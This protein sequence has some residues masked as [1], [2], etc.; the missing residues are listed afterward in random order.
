MSHRYLTAP[1]QVRAVD[2]GPAT[3]IVNYRSGQVDTLIGPAARWW[4]ELA[5]SGDTDT[6]AALDHVT[7][8]TLRGQLLEAG[9]LTPSAQPTPWPV[10]TTGPAW[11]PSWGTHELAAGRTTPVP[12]PRTITM[13]AGL[14]L[15]LVLATL[16]AGRPHRRMARLTWLLQRSTRHTSRSATTERAEQAVYAVRRA[17]LLAP[18]RVACLEESAAV[19][20][21]LAASRHRVMWC[22]GAAADP[23]RLHAWVETEDRQSVAEPASTA[24][25]AVLRTIPARD[26]GGESD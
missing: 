23:V 17:G 4:T 25:F 19:L 18:G 15:A 9:L 26:D 10:P 24:R 13:V 12:V 16:A 1:A 20:V 7:A 2:V 14:A 11:E 8:R 21:L 3:V 6:P 5:T 22:H